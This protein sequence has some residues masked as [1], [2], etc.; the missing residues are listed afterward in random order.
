MKRRQFLATAIAIAAIPLPARAQA[1]PITLQNA[2]WSLAVDPQTLAISAQP[3]NQPAIKVSNGVPNHSPTDIAHTDA[4]AS[5]TWDNAYR[6]AVALKD[7]DLD[8]TVTA[9]QPGTL[10]ILDQPAQAT[11]RGLILPLSEGSYIPAGNALW[12]DFLIGHKNEHRDTTYD[13]S[14]PLWGLDHHDV[15]MHW[16]LGNPFNNK[17]KF[18]AEGEGMGLTL[19][20]EFTT[21]SPTTPMTMTL[22]LGAGDLLAGARRYRQYLIDTGA[23]ESLTSKI[24]KTPDAR[25]LIGA[26][27]VYLWGN[28]LLGEGD[29][30]DWAGFLKILNGPSP[31]AVR[32][33]GA[34]EKDAAEMLKTLPT[35]PAAWQQAALIAA[36]NDALN[37]LGR[38]RWQTDAADSAL[39]VATYPD[40]CHQVVATFGKTLA[41]DPAKWGRG[42]SQKTFADLKAAGL[43]KLWIGLGDGWEGGLWHPEAVASAVK[44]G[45]LIGPYD[46]YETAVAPG[47]RADWST[48][49]LGQA[50]FDNCG[51]VNKDGT[52]RDG[53]QK[54]GHYTN[55]QCVM[56]ILKDRIAAIKKAAGF[57]SLFLD[58]YATGMVFDDFRPGHEMTMAQNVTADTDSMRWIS[59]DMQMPLGSEDGKAIV[60][61]GVLFA[62]GMEMPVFGWSDPDLQ[63][64]KTSPYYLGEYWPSGQPGIFFKQVPMKEPYRTLYCAPEFRLPLYQAALHGSVITTHHWSYD[65]LKLT[66][67]TKL[68]ELTE[69]LYNVPPLYHLSVETMKTRVPIMQEHDAFFRPLH[70]ALAE[71]TMDGFTWSEDRM[72]QATTFSDCSR[73][74]ANFAEEARTLDGLD[75]PPKSVTAMLKNKLALTYQA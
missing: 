31:F 20:H 71:L 45:Y 51:V 41:P 23:Y 48:A 55:A 27:H 38:A 67:V 15:T 13:L 12:R 32:L 8:I 64:D 53:F 56:P 25:K 69:L 10:D 1:T 37:V 65:S 5:W 36:V 16:L 63:K 19:S 34:F 22:H 58:V 2:L 57:N 14:L 46:S 73:M 17:L 24:A 42:L 7:R 47:V 49:Q 39:I 26:S 43:Q 66:N 3:V 72:V 40:L 59:R 35:K 28:G 50:A 18:Q 9:T 75:L 61:G 44:A 60:T 30:R 70:E 29:V 11:G 68:R 74:I 52:V 4:T 33:R 21:L 54:T 6:I 62:H